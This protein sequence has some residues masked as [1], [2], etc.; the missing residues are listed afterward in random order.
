MYGCITASVS[1]KCGDKCPQT[2]H[3]IIKPCDPIAGT[4]P[5]GGCQRGYTGRTCSR[6]M[7]KCFVLTFIYKLII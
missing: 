3:C 6:G 4:C 7:H 5:P 2:C 1:G